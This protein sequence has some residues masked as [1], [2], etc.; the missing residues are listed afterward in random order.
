MR[1][2]GDVIAVVEADFTFERAVFLQFGPAIAARFL[3]L[4]VAF[5][6]ELDGVAIASLVDGAREES[7]ANSPP[8]LAKRR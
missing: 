1:D 2:E 4:V 8:S 5:P 7:K 3:H 6:G